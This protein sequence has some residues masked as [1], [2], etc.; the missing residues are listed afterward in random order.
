MVYGL[1]GGAAGVLIG[2]PAA[3]YLDRVG[4]DFRADEIQGL[5]FAVTT[6]HGHFGAGSVAAGLSVGVLLA[7][8]GTVIPVI[9]TFSMG[10]QDAMTR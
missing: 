4:I 3:Y 2:S 6:I 8:L 10:P 9:K 1:A 5:P 7:V